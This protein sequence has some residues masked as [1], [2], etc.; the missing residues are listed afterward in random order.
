M[1]HPNQDYWEPFCRAIGKL[2]WINDPLYATMESREEN[3]EELIKLLDDLFLSRTWAEWEKNFIENDLIASANQSIP[4]ILEDEQA[5]VNNFFTDIDHPVTGTARMLNSPVQFS[6]TP[7]RIKNAAPPVGSHTE[8]VLLEHGY[9]W[10]DI[11]RFK[12]QGAIP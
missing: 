9:G 10:E 11:E 4:E 3:C 6:E 1:V 8:E 7:A 12:E 2:E 5:I